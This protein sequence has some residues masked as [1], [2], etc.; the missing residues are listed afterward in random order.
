MNKAFNFYL[1]PVD[2]INQVCANDS[3]CFTVKEFSYEET[4]FY[5]RAIARGF[6]VQPCGRISGYVAPL[7]QP[8]T[9]LIPSEICMGAG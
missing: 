7:F 8:C 2:D 3:H 4:E 9:W 6:K 1:A 5:K